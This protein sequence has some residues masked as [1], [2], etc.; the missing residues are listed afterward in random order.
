MEDDSVYLINH[1]QRLRKK[2]TLPEVLVELNYLNNF[3]G[4][5]A[6]DFTWKSDDEIQ[7]LDKKTYKILKKEWQ[8]GGYK[9]AFALLKKNCKLN[10]CCHAD[11]YI[12]VDKNG[13]KYSCDEEYYRDRIKN[14][15]HKAKLIYDNKYDC[16]GDIARYGK[17]WEIYINVLN[18]FEPSQYLHEIPPQQPAADR[19]G[20]ACTED[21]D[22]DD[23]DDG[24]W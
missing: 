11:G 21:D 8:D 16:A 18:E 19:L 14:L 12:E 22:E 23:D 20:Q 15:C 6:G 17:F 4:Y 1:T 9:L 24:P 7:I 5:H 13:N 3:A 10:W 2:T